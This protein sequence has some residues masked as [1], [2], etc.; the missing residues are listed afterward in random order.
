MGE[1]GAMILA[2]AGSGDRSGTTGTGGGYEE[3]TGT[4]TAL[5]NPPKDVIALVSD[6]DDI[7]EQ[8][9]AAI[10]G[11][12]ATTLFQYADSTGSAG[13]QQTT[14]VGGSGV[15][16]KEWLTDYNCD[17]GDA[18]GLPGYPLSPTRG[19]GVAIV[20]YCTDGVQVTESACIAEF[21]CT[22]P[23]RCVGVTNSP[24]TATVQG[25]CGT[26]ATAANQPTA[27]DRF[28]QAECVKDSDGDGSADGTW[29]AGL[30]GSGNSA[31]VT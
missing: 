27:T 23:G 11:C 7:S 3:G 14:A 30:D 18:G 9:T 15:F 20:G 2:T 4:G 19:D 22:V 12:R 31:W 17:S 6:N 5:N 25:E 29:T 16:K 8:T 10:A 24:T 28:T 13:G 21:F 26:C 1:A